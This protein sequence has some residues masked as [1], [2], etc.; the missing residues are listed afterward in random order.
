[1][2]SMNERVRKL[3]GRI[4]PPP[5]AR[6]QSPQYERLLAHMDHRRAWLDYEDRKASAEAGGRLEALEPP[7]PL[8]PLTLDEMKDELETSLRFLN[9]YIPSWRADRGQENRA[10]LD[11]MER[12]TRESVERMRREIRAKVEGSES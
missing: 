8:P 12:R 4:K 3:R 10:L 6:P 2:A 7:E 1:V 5:E 11:D 9:E